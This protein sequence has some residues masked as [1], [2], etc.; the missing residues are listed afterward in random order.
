MAACRHSTHSLGRSG[1]SGALMPFRDEAR[2]RPLPA[3]LH[4]ALMRWF[5]SVYWC[6][7]QRHPDHRH[8]SCSL[9]PSRAHAAGN[10]LF[11]PLFLLSRQ[12]RRSP[13]LCSVRQPVD[14]SNTTVFVGNLTSGDVTAAQLEALFQPVGRVA[15]ASATRYSVGC[16][17]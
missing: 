7:R 15:Q 11:L 10:L 3:P 2:L 16:I 1:A 4:A 12:H 5:P 13:C 9:L 17:Q 8:T 14:P 6:R